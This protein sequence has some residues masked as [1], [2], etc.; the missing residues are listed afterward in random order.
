MNDQV[1]QNPPEA[2]PPEPEKTLLE[3]LRECKNRKEGRAAI[4]AH[5]EAIGVDAD[6]FLISQKELFAFSALK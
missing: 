2:L 5:C 3:K 4:E 6:K 1:A